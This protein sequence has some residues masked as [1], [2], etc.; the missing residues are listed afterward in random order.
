MRTGILRLPAAAFACV[1]GLLTSCY[2]PPPPIYVVR[3]PQGSLC[4]QG[5]FYYDAGYYVSAYHLLLQSAAAHSPCGLNN[6]GNYYFEGKAVA[7]NLP[8]ALW[9]WRKSAALGYPGAEYN[10]G[11]LYEGEEGIAADWPRALKLLKAAAHQGYIQAELELA[12]IYDDRYHKTKSLLDFEKSKNYY[13]I[14]YKRNQLESCG[15][16]IDLATLYRFASGV[17]DHFRKSF[18]WDMRCAGAPAAQE[19]I[20]Y[21]YIKG[22]GVKKNLAE[23]LYWMHLA[24][25]RGSKFARQWIAYYDFYG[26]NGAPPQTSVDPAKSGRLIEQAHKILFKNQPI[27]PHNLRL[28]SHAVNMFRE[29]AML[30]DAD[31]QQYLADEY[32]AGLPAPFD[33]KKSHMFSYLIDPQPTEAYVWYSIAA[34]NRGLMQVQRRYVHDRLHELQIK[35]GRDQLRRANVEI[36]ELEVTLPH[37]RQ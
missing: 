13:V 17:P 20:G 24:A 8:K 30:G 10:L 27:T 33:P 3:P 34:S 18:E 1:A 7:K 16:A 4:Q 35:L 15:A 37:R 12:S 28:Y 26:S 23:G 14:A 36:S 22:Q 21:D 6:L 11:V 5:I 25:R 19:N 29:A 31:G 32:Y 2:L 9:L